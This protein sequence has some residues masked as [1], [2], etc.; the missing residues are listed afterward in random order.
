VEELDAKPQ[1]KKKKLEEKEKQK[2][3]SCIWPLYITSLVCDYIEAHT[4]IRIIQKKK[5]KE[6]E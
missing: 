5:E 2:K 4:T 6:D 3:K 1:Q